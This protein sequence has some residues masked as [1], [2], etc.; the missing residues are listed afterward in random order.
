MTPPAPE[1]NQRRDD[2]RPTSG[3]TVEG[4]RW[5]QHEPRLPRQHTPMRPYQVHLRAGG[6]LLGR[7]YGKGPFR[8]N[9][10][11][12]QALVPKPSVMAMTNDTARPELHQPTLIVFESVLRNADAQQ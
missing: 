12:P 9:V 5:R 10:S 4:E 3:V 11:S 7:F 1:R 6:L 8:G 2:E